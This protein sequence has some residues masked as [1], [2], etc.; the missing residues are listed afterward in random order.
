MIVTINE[1][2]WHTVAEDPPVTDWYIVRY[3]DGSTAVACW[4]ASQHRWSSYAKTPD[5]ITHWQTQDSSIIHP[6][7][8][9]PE[10]RKQN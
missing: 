3:A 4:L 10:P 8:T 6:S 2:K 7:T 1:T 9:P 5:K